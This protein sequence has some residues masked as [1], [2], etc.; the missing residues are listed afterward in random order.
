[1]D[2]EDIVGCLGCTVAIIAIMIAPILA[3]GFVIHLLVG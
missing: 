3:I 1:M 2:L